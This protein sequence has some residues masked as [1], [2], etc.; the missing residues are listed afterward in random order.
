MTDP[1]TQ[2]DTLI[3]DIMADTRIPL[4]TYRVQFHPDHMTFQK[5]QEIVPY[6]NTLGISNLYASPVFKPRKESTHGYDIVDYNQFNARLG[7]EDDFNTLSDTLN[8][9][10]MSLL[11][12]IVPNHM[13]ASTENDWWQDV[14]KHGP[15]SI[16]AHYFDIDWRPVNRALDDKVLLPVLGDHY[17]RVLEA[18]ELELVYWHGDFYLHYY[19]HQFPLTPETYVEILRPVHDELTAIKH[20]KDVEQELLSIITALE[21]LPHYRTRDDAQL[22][23]RRREQHVIRRRLLHLW[24]NFESFQQAVSSALETLN[25]SPDDPQSFNTLDA[26]LNRQPYRLSYW[27]VAADEINYRRFFDINDMAAIRIE[28]PDVF[29]DTHRL[30]LRLL[31]EGRLTGL[32]VDH[33]D[34]LWNPRAY[35]MRLQEEYIFARLEADTGNDF[36]NQAIVRDR[37][38]ALTQ[39]HPDEA[40]PWPLY[41]VTEKILS[42]TEPLP[43]TW[44]VYGT[45]GYD[46]MTAANNLLVNPDAEEAFDEVYADF[47]GRDIDFDALTDRTKRLIMDE[48]LTSEIDARSAELARIVEQNRRY[49]GFTRNS[50]AFAMK[51]FIVALP[52][53]RT[54]ITGPA[55]VSDRDRYY[56]D[57]AI[58]HARKHNPLTPE[59]VFDFLRD[60]LLMA[61]IRDFDEHRR[62]ALREFVQKFQQITGPV[63]AKSVEDTAFYI[64]NRLVALNEVGGHPDQFGISTD[65]FHKQYTDR[66]FSYAMLSTSTHDT[67]RSEDVRARLAV[68]S[69][70]PG[71]W[72]DKLHEW[73][74]LNAS[75]KTRVQ[76]D[77][78]PS[79]ND[80]Y[81]LY[82]TLIGAYQPQDSDDLNTFEKRIVRY[83][84]KALNEAKVH[85]N[86]VNPNPPYQEATADFVHALLH[87]DA[88]MQSFEPFQRDVSFFGWINSLTQTLLKLT[89]PGVPDIYQGN[90]LWDYSLVDPDNRRPVDYETRQQLLDD[91]QAQEDENRLQLAQH[92]TQTLDSGAIKLYTTYRALILRREM[93]DVFLDGAYIP[94]EAEGEKS[95]HVCAFVR[96]TDETALLTVVPRLPYRL[97]Q[98]QTRLPVGSDVW[99]DTHLLL[100]ED[101]NAASLENLFTGE[102]FPVEAHLRTPVRLSEALDIFP[103]GLLRIHAD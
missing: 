43:Y 62:A 18:G 31:A 35:F 69:E 75:A 98:G 96:Q 90:E 82:Q 26:I 66:D 76:D 36:R 11:L 77:P 58:D 55:D 27:R 34:G 85:S 8:D 5:A 46:F 7:T 79:R 39:R 56:I 80:E 38:E 33:S 6:L 2:V 92:L 71:L 54:Y 53:Y 28:A 64:Y 91:I 88:F 86:W 45:T 25:G 60:T 50:I 20:D 84:K 68:L 100:P 24:D 9:H 81:L 29:M 44:A 51:E 49:R 3:D 95:G 65:L 37:L 103:V 21:H 89:V 30:T 13:G 63:M 19:E 72:R 10:D 17:G 70:M 32:R 47:I 23:T 1:R 94:V 61:N 78:A 59:S 99:G 102:T 42:E 57:T 74:E 40:A 101:L 14:L 22:T 67:K 87:N 93:P 16:Y 52:I 15:A 4:A 73:A 12:D 97:L 83:M 48:S 41:I